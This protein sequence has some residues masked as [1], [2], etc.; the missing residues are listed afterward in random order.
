[1]ATD[2]VR[3]CQISNDSDSMFLKYFKMSTINITDVLKYTAK[4][5]C[6]QTVELYCVKQEVVFLKAYSRKKNS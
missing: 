3:T 5:T 6:I 1:M 2:L 4:I